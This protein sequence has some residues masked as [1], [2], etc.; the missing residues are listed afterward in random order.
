MLL[1]FRKQPDSTLDLSHFR[2]RSTPHA[3][4]VTRTPYPTTKI[5]MVRPIRIYAFE[6]RDSALSPALPLVVVCSI[7]VSA[8]SIRSLKPPRTA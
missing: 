7:F 8:P 4:T 6:P 1:L 5:S 2:P 3:S